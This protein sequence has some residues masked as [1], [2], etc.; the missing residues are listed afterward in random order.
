[1]KKIIIVAIFITISNFMPA[2][3]DT[4]IVKSGEN[5]SDSLDRTALKGEAVSFIVVFENFKK[6]AKITNEDDFNKLLE[7]FAPEQRPYI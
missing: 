7:Q 4:V 3:G 2:L 6:E 1:M 5:I